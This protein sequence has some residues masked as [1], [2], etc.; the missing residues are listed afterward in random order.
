MAG[1]LL[2]LAVFVVVCAAIGYVTNVL[3]VKMIYRPYERVEVLGVGFQGVLPKHQEHFAKML[4]G[5]IVRDFLSISDLVEE[6]RKPEAIADLRKAARELGLEV[7]RDLRSALPPDRQALVSDATVG[8]LVDRVAEAI[9]AS[10]PDWIEDL[11]RRAD[12][13]VDLEAIVAEKLVAI[14]PRGLESIIYEV[15]RREMTWIELYGGVFGALLGVLQWGVLLLLGDIALPLV[16]G[17]VGIVTNWLAIQ[18]LFYPREERVFLGLVRYQGMF[19][20]RQAEMATEMGRIAARDL[21]VPGELFRLLAHRLLPVSANPGHPDPAL[22]A[23]A[24][25]WLR[26]NVPPLALVLDRVLTP[27]DRHAVLAVLETRHPDLFQTI[28]ARLLAAATHHVRVDRLLAERV[29]R[30]PRSGFEALLRGLFD[31]EELYLIL[32]GGLLGALMGGLQL[33]LVAA[34]D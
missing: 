1:D 30:L 19:P 9:E 16:G 29:S 11:K 14:G 21:I 7:V 32:Y 24:E 34:F 15:S 17:V 5:I 12:G 13:A 28:L 23:E 20:R 25:R 4:A 6:L 10:L 3:A 18:M 2:L 27:E 8:A 33:A 26:A 22:V 31:Q